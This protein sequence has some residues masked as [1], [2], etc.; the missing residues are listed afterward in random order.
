[1]RYL[2]EGLAYEVPRERRPLEDWV[3]LHGASEHNLKDLDVA[4]PLGA[5][6]VVTGVSGSGK[7]TLVCDVLYP[8]LRVPAPGHAAAFRG[9]EGAEKVGKVLM[10]DQSPIGKTPRSNP[11]T[12]IHAFQYI[13]EIFAAQSLARERGYGPGRFSFNLSGGRCSRCQGMGYEKVEM[14]FM[15]DL[16]VP[17]PEC[18]GL[19]FNRETLEVT[20]RGKN[21]AEVLDLSVDEAIRHFAGCDRLVKRLRVLQEVGLGYLKLGQPSHTLSGGEAQRMKIARELGEGPEGGAF[22]ILD[23]PTTGLHPDDVRQL[24]KVLSKLVDRGNT[25]VVIEHNLQVILQADWVIDLGPEGGDE[26]G[27]IVCAGRPEEVAACP[28]SHT[29]RFLKQALDRAAGRP[30][31]KRGV[32]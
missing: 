20:Y 27:R 15:A 3:R 7:S 30:R 4:F 32:A 28:D 8:A 24:V 6:T 26:G 21:L 10:V 29:G 23:E 5:L 12:Y 16:F 14:H 31:R 25:V 9:I 2:Q 11:I 17:C 13:R 1:V 22:Y 18:G 19:R